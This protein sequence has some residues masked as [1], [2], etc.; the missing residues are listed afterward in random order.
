MSTQSL[1]HL[2]SELATDPDLAEIVE[3]FVEEMPQRVAKLVQC[4]DQH[5]LEN[6]GRAA[7]QLKGSAGSY[8]FMPIT[9]AAAKLETLVRSQQDEDEILVALNELVDLCQS[10]RSGVPTQST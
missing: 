8:G 3:M 7:H 2:Y 1:P 9:P 4:Y 10:I 6:L 5:D